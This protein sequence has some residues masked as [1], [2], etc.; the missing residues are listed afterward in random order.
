MLLALWT[1]KVHKTGGEALMSNKV[2]MVRVTKAESERRGRAR[3]L[4]PLAKEQSGAT[5]TDSS[6]PVE[7]Q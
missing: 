4:V 3:A 1:I 7:R 2:R 5:R 6:S